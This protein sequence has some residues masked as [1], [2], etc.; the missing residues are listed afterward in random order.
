MN[1][2]NVDFFNLGDFEEIPGIGKHGMVRVPQN[3]RN[4]LKL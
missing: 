3:V 2:E 4:Q 1:L